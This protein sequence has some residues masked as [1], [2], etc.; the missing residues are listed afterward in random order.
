MKLTAVVAGTLARCR[1]LQGETFDQYE[2]SML[3]GEKEKGRLLAPFPQSR[4]ATA[5][6][7]S[8]VLPGQADT[9]SITGSA[10]A[11]RRAATLSVA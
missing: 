8:P 10:R 11:L 6:E 2:L 7:H 5:F 3:G 9:T 4:N 1:S